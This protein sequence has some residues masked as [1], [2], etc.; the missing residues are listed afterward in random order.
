VTQE[1]LLG[2]PL[3]E[4]RLGGD[5][6]SF[7][8]N[9]LQHPGGIRV[10]TISSLIHCANVQQRRTEGVDDATFRRVTGSDDRN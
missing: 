8:N 3:G 10:G 7:C 2:C 1:Y 4:F 9:V 6:Y 5:S